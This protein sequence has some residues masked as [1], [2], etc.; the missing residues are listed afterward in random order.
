MS[1]SSRSNLVLVRLQ[2][3]SISNGSTPQNTAKEDFKKKLQDGPDFQD[4]LALD[5]KSVEEKYKEQGI[6]LKRVKGERLRLP[7]WLKTQI[8]IGKNFSQ[9][10]ETLRDKK[11]STVCEEAKCPNIGMFFFLVYKTSQK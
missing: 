9:L 11:L 4:F 2:S 1:N 10:K 5:P 3:N 6:N 8:P 7:P